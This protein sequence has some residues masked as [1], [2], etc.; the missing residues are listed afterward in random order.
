VPRPT[1]DSVRPLGRQRTYIYHRQKKRRGRANIDASP[2]RRITTTWLPAGQLR[3]ADITI[4]APFCR[5]GKPGRGAQQKATNPRF[6]ICHVTEDKSG[7][8]NPRRGK[9]NGTGLIPRVWTCAVPH[10]EGGDLWGV[11]SGSTNGQGSTRCLERMVFFSLFA[12]LPSKLLWVHKIEIRWCET[13]WWAQT[14]KTKQVT[15]CHQGERKKRR[16]VPVQRTL[17]GPD[18][19]RGAA[20]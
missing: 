7:E 20:S 9:A 5:C 14:S 10:L 15:T 6:K 11:P 13:R 4:S 3:R 19:K 17:R 2:A 1:T 12:H 16:K 18:N 8:S